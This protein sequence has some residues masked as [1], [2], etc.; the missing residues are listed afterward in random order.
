MGRRQIEEDDEFD[1]DRPSTRRRRGKPRA[2]TISSVNTKRV[3]IICAIVCLPLLAIGGVVADV[4]AQNRR[5]DRV[6]LRID[7]AKMSYNQKQYEL[8]RVEL[9]S[10]SYELAM[11]SPR[12]VS[13]RHQISQERIATL[14][15]D[16]QFFER[17]NQPGR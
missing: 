10:A 14:E 3:L 12:W 9:N 11:T 7:M 6:A 17:L 4:F 16:L 13:D 1:D 8:A 15:K 5:M 2:S